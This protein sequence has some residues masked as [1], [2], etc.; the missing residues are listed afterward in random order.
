MKINYKTLVQQQVMY[1]WM[2]VK[3]NVN[4]KEAGLYF[5]LPKKKK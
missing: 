4:K 3:I 1:G 2:E 5:E